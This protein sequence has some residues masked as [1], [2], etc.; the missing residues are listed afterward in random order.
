MMASGVALYLMLWPIMTSDVEG[1]FTP[2][3]E[4][5]AATGALR[6]FSAPFGDYAPPYLYVL[7]LAAPLLGMVPSDTIV[8]LVSLAGT[9]M[10]AV[11]VWRLLRAMDAPN[12]ERHALYALLLPGVLMNT[13]LMAQCDALYAAPT[14]MAVTA[15]WQRRHRSMFLWCGLAVAVKLQAILIA[16][17]FLAVAIQRRIPL[18]WWLLA[19][20]A[21]ILANLPAA[22]AG[23]PIGDLAMVYFKR[24]TFYP[25]LSRNA[26]NIWAIVQ[27]LPGIDP[28]A[29]A[30]IADAV[31]IAASALYLWWVLRRPLLGRRLV[32]AAALAPMVTAGLLPHMHERFFYVA[33][34]LIFVWAITGT[35]RDRCTAALVQ[36]GSFLGI[37]AY[38][39]GTE[40]LA[41]LGALA[42]LEAT[43]QTAGSLAPTH[44]PPLVGG[45]RVGV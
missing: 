19:P 5:I 38:G 31:A 6:A 34:V 9:L 3:L 1:S 32:A 10:L 7:A 44:L 39:N 17:F 21:L 15:A 22:L 29:T 23:W 40:K 4:H 43:R 20:L 37:M 24:T 28:I 2:W 8:K 14:I 30:R 13:A 35:V 18:Q 42:M 11:S 16:P 33:D 45:G 41:M 12:P 25:E 27:V 26:P 36:T